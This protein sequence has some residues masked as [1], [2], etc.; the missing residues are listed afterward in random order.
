M[1]TKKTKEVPGTKE[2]PI[3]A[4]FD[5]QEGDPYQRGDLVFVQGKDCVIVEVIAE[6]RFHVKNIDSPYDSFIVLVGELE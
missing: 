1:A 3:L 2:N 4:A 5:G 6:G